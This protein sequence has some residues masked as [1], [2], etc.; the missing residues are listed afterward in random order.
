SKR[1]RIHLADRRHL[2]DFFVFLMLLDWYELDML[3]LRKN[4]SRRALGVWLRRWRDLIEVAAVAT[5]A[6]VLRRRPSVA[7]LYPA[8]APVRSDVL[9]V[10]RTGSS[11]T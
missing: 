10:P 2:T 7:D 8:G 3:P 9:R 4:F 6:A 1:L 11:S 5:R